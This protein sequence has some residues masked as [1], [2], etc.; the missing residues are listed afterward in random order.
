MLARITLAAALV[1]GAA[2]AAQAGGDFDDT[3]G[4]RGGFHVGPDGQL[5][6]GPR[7]FA[8][9]RAYAYVPRNQPF[10]YN[11]AYAYAPRYQRR[12]LYED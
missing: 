10:A 3:G 1:L 7:P 2:A 6:G 5:L 12:W 9:N 4:A 11:R 8:Y